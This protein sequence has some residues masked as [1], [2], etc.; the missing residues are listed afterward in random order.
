MVLTEL[1]RRWMAEK[2]AQRFLC[3]TKPVFSSL[4][5]VR[6][7]TSSTMEPKLS[8]ST[9]CQL[10]GTLVPV[11]GAGPC[12]GQS[13]GLGQVMQGASRAVRVDFVCRQQLAV[14]CTACDT[15]LDQPSTPPESQDTT[16]PPH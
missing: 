14:R 10:G 15:D 7:V 3:Q 5:P 2:R 4:P 16:L 11:G 6:A 1:R 12:P 13:W 9:S 8:R